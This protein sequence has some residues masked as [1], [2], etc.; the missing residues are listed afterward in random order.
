[1]AST[2]FKDFKDCLNGRISLNADPNIYFDKAFAS[3]SC[4]KAA[5]VAVPSQLQAMI[6]LAALP[7]KWEMLISVITSN[8]NL[9]DLE[10]SNVRTVV[11]TQF[12][13]DSVCHGSGKH[14]TN[15]ISMVKRKRGNPN[16]QN[17]QG[18]SNQQQRNNQQQQGQDGQKHKC[19]KHTSKGKAKQADHSQ[20]HFHIANVASMVPPTSSTIALPAPSGMQK[21]TITHPLPKQCTPSPYKA[22][23]AAIDTA[24]A[25]G[26]KPTIQMVKTLEQ[27]ITDTY[28][29]SPWAKVS[30]ISDVENSDV[31]M[32]A[33]QGKEDQGDWVF[34]EADEETSQTSEEGKADPSFKP[35]S[36]SAKP[37]DWGSDLDDGEVCVCPSSLL[38]LVH[39]LTES[40]Q[41]LKR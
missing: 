5:G 15:K 14:N 30:H 31:E 8:N 12:Q 32:H 36:P 11:I 10:L 27:R 40:H 4:M 34:E 21:R 16:W 35:L 18:G 7:Q 38:C 26:S 20:Q 37:L 41:L 9:E 17:Q 29:E 3:Y 33:L 1:M 19:G 25:S 23:N 24:Q 39:N 13:V 2:I 28:L 22:F 6:A